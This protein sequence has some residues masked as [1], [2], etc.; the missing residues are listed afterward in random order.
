MLIKL[1]NLTTNQLSIDLGTYKG[2]QV[3]KVI[4]AGSYVDVGD[5]MTPEEVNKDSQIQSLVSA[6]TL[7]V[8]VVLESTDI[9][10]LLDSQILS[11]QQTTATDVTLPLGF[12]LQ[13]GKVVSVKACNDAIPASGESMS[14]DIERAVA[15]SANFETVLAT[16]LLIDETTGAVPG[17]VVSGTVTGEV[18]ATETL[19]VSGGN[20]QDSEVA[21]IGGKT[22][23]FQDTLTNV[24]GHVKVGTDADTSL[25]NLIA[26]INLGS[27]A[28]TA[29]A[30]AT[31]RHTTV[32]ATAG[33]T[34]E[35][36]VVANVT[37]PSG[38]DIAVYTTMAH[39]S[40]VG[41]YLT[42]GAS[43]V[44]SA[45]DRFQAVLDYTAGGTTPIINTRIEVTLSKP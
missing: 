31:T 37:G 28:G 45:G 3:R 10:S 4:P 22:Y 21:I 35:M 32:G 39:G 23:T 9:S 7:S 19:T 24:D 43:P 11:L 30:V 34:G 40:W 26:A 1:N 8:T 38:N 20:A 33:G 17:A 36:D 16:S 25:A 41:S 14:I 44:V 42:G 29:Y 13:S 6:G 18:A 15:G 12:A 2:T 5:I 27:G